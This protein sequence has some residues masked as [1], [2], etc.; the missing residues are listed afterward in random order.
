MSS[1]SVALDK[2]RA[3]IVARAKEMRLSLKALSGALG[4]ND[5][6][7]HQFINRG[8]P[9][10]L[11]YTEI[12]RLAEILHLAPQEVSHDPIQS[13]PKR[14][15]SAPPLIPFHAQNAGEIPLFQ[16]GDEI[17]RG[18]AVQ[19]TPAPILGH[20]ASSL[21]VWITEPHG[22]LQ[23]GDM[24]YIREHQPATIG[25]LVVALK[26]KRITHIGNLLEY[27]QDSFKIEIE[28]RK[29]TLKRADH[30]ILKVT[31]AQFS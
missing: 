4:K 10:K 12:M 9:R 27:G 7:M 26:D 14:D 1:D 3:A 2:V 19:Y 16:E 5:S 15:T 22:R 11:Q 28:G 25:D 23:R 29:L 30:K 8:S 13:L 21:A 24:A 20:A 6:Y 17:D 18:K 31:S